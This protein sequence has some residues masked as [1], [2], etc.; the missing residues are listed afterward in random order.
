MDRLL[1]EFSVRTMLIAA[2]TA[3]ALWAFRIRNASTRHATWASVVLVMMLLPL[4]TAWGPKAPVR[5]LPTVAEKTG[6]NPGPLPLILPMAHASALEHS[7]KFVWPVAIYLLGVCALLARL[8]L[9]TVRANRLAGQ[10]TEHNGMLTSASC[11]APIAV[12]FLRPRVILPEY[13]GNWSEAQLNAVLVHEREHVRRRDPLVQWVAL[14][15]RAIFWFHPLAWWLERRL[16]AL[17]EE[18]CDDA[19]LES[20]HDARDYSE[21]LLDIAR[22]VMQAGGRVHVMGAAMP[23]GFLP[24]R[25]RKILD[26]PLA[27]KISRARMLCLAGAC[28]LITALFAAGTLDH[29]R[30]RV[31]QSVAVPIPA[32]VPTAAQP[33][34]KRPQVTLA[35][36]APKPA[37]VPAQ[38]M[39]DPY[40]KWLD[41]EAVYIITPQERATF[42]GL[43]SD[44]QRQQF[45]QQFWSRRDPAGGPPNAFREEHYRRIAFANDRFGFANTVGWRTDRGR[46]YIQFGAPDQTEDHPAASIPS[47]RWR[48]RYI[49]GLGNDVT[50]EFVDPAKNGEYRMTMDPG[51]KGTEIR[52]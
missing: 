47:E 22:S 19:V 44:Q 42:L 31:A 33:I 37:P 43:G 9:G 26:A 17:A 25:L 30:E 5:V 45:I 12:G 46:I 1:W 14:L 34:D 39:P 36:A 3:A 10:A 48:Y 38:Q 11:T 32:A 49:E 51:A 20:G 4:W 8:F 40:R 24:G 29:A 50:M 52:R 2:G 28:A 18:V 15:N 23:G 27:P 35:Q 13:W 7:T 16:S 21:Y 6:P 41:E